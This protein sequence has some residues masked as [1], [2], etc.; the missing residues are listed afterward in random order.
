MKKL[1]YLFVLVVLLGAF[2]TA[3]L[4]QALERKDTG[5]TKNNSVLKVKSTPS[6]SVTPKDQGSQNKMNVAPKKMDAIRLHFNNMV[7]KIQAAINRESKLA[8]RIE[9]RLNK[10]EAAGK[11]ISALR[12]KLADARMTIKDAQK[13]LDD[14]KAQMENVLKSENIKQAFQSVKALIKNAVDKVKLA[15][16]K[17]VDIINSIKGMSPADCKAVSDCGKP[18]VCKDGKEY[19]AWA[20]NDGKCDQ[21]KYF[22]D[23]CSPLPSVSAAASN[24][25]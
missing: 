4:A 17:L 14:A 6:L 7:R 3:G 8:D 5:P 15:H 19:P 1:I 22:R 25:Q 10:L 2:L 13:Y 18:L 16:Q 23:P 11:D 20:C 9:L 24:Q 12:V 21:I